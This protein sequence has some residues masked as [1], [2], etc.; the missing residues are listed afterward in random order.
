MHVTLQH[1][2]GGAMETAE[3]A[4][5]AAD[6]PAEK[7]VVLLV[8]DEA[9]ITAVYARQLRKHGMTV[10]VATDAVAAAELVRTRTFDV[11]VSDV[12]MPGMSGLELP[13]GGHAISDRAGLESRFS[14]ALDTLWM[15]YQPIVSWAARCVYAHEALVRTDE[16][17]LR[18]P[19]DLLDAAERLGRLRD[20]GRT[21]RASAAQT[22][23]E[24]PSL[25][26]L[27]FVNLH[28]EDLADEDLI[29]PRAPLSAFAL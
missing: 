5:K 29:S 21:I 2:D 14:N 23:T 9:N 13:R 8:D 11:V 7:G 1:R 27:L 3:S 22:L 24:H 16:A 19:D 17:T 6:R 10:E 4:S 26:G 25:E 18:R 28:T 12:T 15:A 20:L